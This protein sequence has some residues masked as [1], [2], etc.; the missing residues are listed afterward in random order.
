MKISQS[1]FNKPSVVNKKYINKRFFNHERYIQFTDK[2]KAEWL[3]NTAE[4]KRNNE[5]R[6]AMMFMA[7]TMYS[8]CKKAQSFLL[9]KRIDHI[10]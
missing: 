2:K 6:I 1:A 8:Q 10:I 4:R 3:A 7:L 5:E 9:E